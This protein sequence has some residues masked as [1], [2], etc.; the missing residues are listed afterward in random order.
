MKKP[1]SNLKKTT[2]GVKI[3]SVFDIIKKLNQI[4]NSSFSKP[5]WFKVIIKH[6]NKNTW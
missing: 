1:S 2:D 3:K 6:A 4:K 5:F